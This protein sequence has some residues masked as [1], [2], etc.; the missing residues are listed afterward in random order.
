MSME[1]RAAQ[2]APFAALTGHDDAIF[3]TARLTDEK[4]ELTSDEL[5]ELSKK[6]EYAIV[7]K[8]SVTIAYFV[9]DVNKAGGHYVSITGKVKTIDEYDSNLKMDNGHVI[10]LGSIISISGAI[11]DNLI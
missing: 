3:E 7:M 11:F 2:F 6:L 8:A 5:A 9:K 10:P 4:I 1:N